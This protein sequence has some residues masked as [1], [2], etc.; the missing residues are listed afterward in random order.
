MIKFEEVSYTYQKNTPYE[1]QALNQISTE[2]LPGRYYAIIGKTG[3]GKS[4]LI[5]HFNG[6][7]KPTRGKVQVL[8]VTV[9]RKTKDKHLKSIRQRIGM[10]FQFPESQLF[11]ETVEKEVLFGPRNYGLD[12]EE[13]RDKV[14]TLLGELGFDAEK[15]MQQ[16]PFLL[17]GGQ[18]RKIALAAILAMDPDIL[19][20]DEPTAGLD[21]RSKAQVMALFKKLQLEEGKTI[22]LVTHDMNDVAE[23]ADE[24]KIMQGGT[25][26]ESTT[27]YDFFQRPD[28]V[29]ALHLCLP[30]IVRLQR[31]V[32][33]KLG[34]QF[35]K[36]ALTEASFVA[37][38]EEWRQ[39]HEG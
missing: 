21:P 30:D 22:I 8:D 10:V 14:M 16:S 7:V 33:A 32:E 11:E 15:V 34:V 19:I 38:Y 18:M 28:D 13:A 3:S 2:F 12:I 36:L 27:P 26:I 29:N 9:N 23:F 39:R 1:Y 4:T 24:I 31:D 25:L 20:L 17:S 6:L 37:I 35:D 5:Q